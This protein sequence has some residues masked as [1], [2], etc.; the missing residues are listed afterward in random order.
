LEILQ[1]VFHLENA[2]NRVYV[3]RYLATWV[4]QRKW[5][6]KLKLE[7]PLCMKVLTSDRALHSDV[8]GFLQRTALLSWQ[9]EGTGT[10][11]NLVWQLKPSVQVWRSSQGSTGAE[12]VIIALLRIGHTRLTRGNSLRGYLSTTSRSPLPCYTSYR[13]AHDMAKSAK[14]STLLARCATF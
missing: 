7:K 14:D 2:E 10:V 3:V 11:G 12:E 13:N 4:C 1:Q 8:R 9:D 5:A 6:S